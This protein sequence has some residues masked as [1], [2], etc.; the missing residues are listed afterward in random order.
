MTSIN[1]FPQYKP[2][3]EIST[4]MYEQHISNN[5]YNPSK[6]EIQKSIIFE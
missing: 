1:K 4:D 3:D 2:V 6:L 5:T